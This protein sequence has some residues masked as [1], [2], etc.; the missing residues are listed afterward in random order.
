MSFHFQGPRCKNCIRKNCSRFLDTVL[1]DS[2]SWD[3]RSA[4][5]M[6]TA[7]QVGDIVEFHSSNEGWMTGMNLRSAQTGNFPGNYVVDRPVDA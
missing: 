6:R 4:K 7:N 5:L 3:A 1:P 2:I